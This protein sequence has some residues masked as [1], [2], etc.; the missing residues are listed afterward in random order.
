MVKML[1]VEDLEYSRLT[2][3]LET[4][5]EGV[6]VDVATNYHDAMDLAGKNSYDAY[7]VDG[8]FPKSENEEPELLGIELIR[9]LLFE[10]KIDSKKIFMHS[11]AKEVIE[12]AGKLGINGRLKKDFLE[13]VE[14]MKAELR[15]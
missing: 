15:L 7:L 8:Y 3:I 4:S 10:L 14:E 5:I 11:S 9:H 2:K 12:E 6:E 1:L 13:L